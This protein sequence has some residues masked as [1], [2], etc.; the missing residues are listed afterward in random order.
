[1]KNS[2]ICPKCKGNDILSIRGEAGALG[3]GNVIQAGW[4]GV[5]VHRYVCC[6]CGYS[7]EWVDTKDIPKLKDTYL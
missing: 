5:L 7:E 4:F 3:S 1:M 2:G 6:D